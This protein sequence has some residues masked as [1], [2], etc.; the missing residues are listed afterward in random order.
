MAAPLSFSI[1]SDIPSVTIDLSF[2]DC[3]YPFPND[4]SINGEGYDLVG[5]LY[6]LGIT[7]ADEYRTIIVIKRIS[8]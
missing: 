8:L 6:I 7:F 1:C 5:K 2:S 4:F 3:C